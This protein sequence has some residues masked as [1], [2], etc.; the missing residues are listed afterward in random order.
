MK[1]IPALEPQK[2]FDRGKPCPPSCDFGTTCVFYFYFAASLCAAMYWMNH[3]R[4]WG[5]CAICCNY[6]YIQVIFLFWSVNF[7]RLGNKFLL[8]N[9]NVSIN[10]SL[11][12]IM[13]LNEYRIKRKRNTYDFILTV[14]QPCLLLYGKMGHFFF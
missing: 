8:E 13:K 7:R 11:F 12:M 9:V 4:L 3:K 1:R 14:N 2:V 10:C 6:F 5:Y